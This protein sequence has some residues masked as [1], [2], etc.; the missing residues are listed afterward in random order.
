MI[1]TAQ[2]GFIKLQDTILIF[3]NVYDKLLTHETVNHSHYS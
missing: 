1:R 3:N 2:K